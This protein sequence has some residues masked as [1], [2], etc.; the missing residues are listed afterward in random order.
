MAL[1]NIAQI[2]ISLPVVRLVQ[3]LVLVGPLHF[4]L[5]SGGGLHHFAVERRV[6]AGLDVLLHRGHRIPVL[7]LDDVWGERCRYEIYLMLRKHAFSP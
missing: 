1:S 6:E 7:E 2:C 3:G 5:L 4:E